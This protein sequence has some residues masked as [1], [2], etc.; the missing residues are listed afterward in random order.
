MQTEI[1]RTA[2]VEDG[3][4]IGEGTRI[5]PY[6]TVGPHVRL[7][8]NNLLHSHVVVDGRTTL[9]DGNEIYPFA[10]LGKI[11]QDLKYRKEWVSYSRIGDGNVFR[12]YVTVNASSLEGES[13]VIGNHGLFLSY[14]HVAHDCRLGDR[15]IVSSDTKMAGHVTIEDHAIV[16]AK[17]GIVQFVRI[18]RFAFIGG[19]NKVAKDI[20]PYSIADGFPSE[21]RG[22]NKIGLERNGFSAATIRVL[23][24]AFRTLIRSGLPLK[25]AV[26]ALDEKYADVP[27]VREMAAFAAASKVGLA[28][29]RKRR[30]AED[31]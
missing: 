30:Q 10:C 26:A 24:E 23:V 5:G 9:G 20:L 13:T 31:E 27:E 6:C 16:G 12:E 25:E 4:E 29:P 18:G 3:A 1:H 17:T 21:I 28:R 8:A 2:I 19:F 7:G 14:S 11:S 15:V 22:I